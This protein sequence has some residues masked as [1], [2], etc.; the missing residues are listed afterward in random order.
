[1]EWMMF[2]GLGLIAITLF[3]IGYLLMRTIRLTDSLQRLEQTL[4][5]EVLHIRHEQSAQSRDGRTE[6]QATLSQQSQTNLKT[7][8]LISNQ[9][10]MVLTDLVQQLDKM[11]SAVEQKLT[12]LQEDN[13]KKLEQMRNTVEEKLQ[14]TLE[15]RLGESFKQVS[16]R[17]EQVHKG[18]G[19]M[20]TLASG[21]GDLK[22]VLANVKTRGTMGEIQLANLLEQT[23]ASDQYDTNAVI[24]PGSQERVE[25]AVKL[26]AK[27]EEKG[28]IYLPIDSKFPVEDYQRL[29]QAQDE[30]NKELEQE[31]IKGLASVIRS[32]AK[33]IRDKYIH[34]P[35]TTDFAV[36]F[37]PFEGLYAEVLRRPGLWEELQRDYRVVVTGPSTL[38]AF[39]NSLQMGFR[40]LAI[41]KRSSEVWQL[42]G[43][44]KAKFGSFATLLARAQKKIEEA[45]RS[46]ESAGVSTRQI[47]KKLAKVQELELSEAGRM[48]ALEQEPDDGDAD[49]D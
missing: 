30:G 14:S 47:E 16:E 31:A 45:G 13:S 18:L 9:Q 43:A 10:Q 36:M 29:L 4:K 49:N 23:F 48:L 20:Q 27:E 7:L 38:S 8:E 39:L 37:L 24:R 11:R 25:F 41:Q 17:L 21:V 22:K 34:P 42:L 2:A 44:V 40:T 5:S 26:P 28:Y 1:M 12:T 33:K 32:E 3:L 46:I 19:E 15:Q 6:L 35:F